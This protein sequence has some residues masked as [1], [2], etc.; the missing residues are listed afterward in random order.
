MPPQEPI[1]IVNAREHN[2]R[3][4]DV[5]LP[6]G[7][8][9]VLAG[10]SG[11]G[12][13]SLAFA[14]LHAEGQRRLMDAFSLRQRT[15]LARLPRPACDAVRGLTATIALEQNAAPPSIRA[16]VGTAS[17]VYE[18]LRV[19]V[20]RA[21]SL[22]CPSCDAQIVHWT[23]ARIALHIE[24]APEGTR[25]LLIAPMIASADTRARLIESGFT[26][27]R[28][29]GAIVRLDEPTI[30]ACFPVPGGTVDVV[31]D[32]L[33]VRPGIRSRIVES[34]E[35]ALRLGDG[36]VSLASADASTTDASD[37]HFSTWWRCAPCGIDLP[38]LTPDLFSFATTASRGTCDAC[39]GTG[40]ATSDVLDAA[41]DEAQAADWTGAPCPLCRG[42]RLT[43]VAR[44]ARFG[45]IRVEVFLAASLQQWPGLL[46]SLDLDEATRAVT[47]EGLAELTERLQTT[48]ALGLGHLKPSLAQ[49]WLS[50]GE[51]QRLRLAGQI[52][53]DLAGVTY[54]IDE[55]SDGL[56][57]D[58]VL[59]VVVALKRLRDRS[60]TVVV[61]EHDPAIVREADWIIDLGPGAGANGGAIVAVGTPD[62]IRKDPASVTG[63]WLDGQPILPA[64]PP[65]DRQAPTISVEIDHYFHFRDLRVDLPIGAITAISGV[66]GVGKSALV[67][68]AIQALVRAHVDRRIAAP[69]FGRLRGA[70]GIERLVVV[71]GA[72]IGRSARSSVVTWLGLFDEIRRL[73]AAMPDARAAGFSA[74]RFS[75]NTPGGRCEPCKGEGV[76]RLDMGFLS[77]HV[78]PCEACQGRRF[79]DATL[80]VRYRGFDIAEILDFTVAEARPVFAAI[81]ALARQLGTL[82]A[83]G[84]GYLRLGQPGYALSGGEA[85]RLRIAREL[86]R[87]G[88]GRGL[89]LLDEPSRGLHAVDLITIAHTLRRLAD[90]GHTVVIAEHAPQ[91]LAVCDHIIDIG[92]GPGEAPRGVIVAGHPTVVAGC[93]ESA[94]GRHLR[95]LIAVPSR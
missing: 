42:L 28:L 21:G 72:P 25:L 54:I 5:S 52:G 94:T 20:G 22:H 19:L 92:P 12:K 73:F 51:A 89:F 50:T 64:A 39:G 30:E 77:E 79:D 29:D 31:V 38:A 34:L 85:Q 63:P 71:D 78:T 45:G 18:V 56:H 82:D 88:T 68:G 49:R 13:S 17:E 74:S 40:L 24:S 91:L 14:T 3:G 1:S 87:P 46:A 9:V 86:A 27:I 58:D 15:A 10:P 6:R 95:E 66:S 62:E 32:R 8:L 23:P 11:S 47:R 35:T 90:A 67:F 84:L 37:A 76:I 26:R 69:S 44:V 75:F 4:V 80:A 57:P 2:L 7:R 55:P 33:I 93:T 60:N 61:V 41:A 16:T 43:H 48:I 83:V 65:L 59:A 53:A 70:D 81:P 36:T